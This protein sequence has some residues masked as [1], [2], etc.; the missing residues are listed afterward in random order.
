MA[1]RATKRRRL[2]PPDDAKP[3]NGM[4]R[5]GKKKTHAAA[6]ADKAL[7][8]GV[9][10]GTTGWD[11]EQEYESRPRKSK[12]EQSSKR[13]R[14]PIKTADGWVEQEPE[15]IPHEASEDEDEDEDSFLGSGEDEDEYEH[16]NGEPAVED[17]QP[18]IPMRQRILQAKEDLAK[19]AGQISEDPETNINAVR[20]L[21][22]FAD[23]PHVPVQKLALATQLAVYK[24][25]IPSYPIRPVKEDEVSSTKV[26]KEVR[27]LRSFEQTLLAGYHKYL[28]RLAGIAK[29]GARESADAAS[30]VTVAFSCA[31]N[32]LVS[33]TH[34]NFRDLLIGIVVRR[35]GRER[36]DGDFRKCVEC[37]ETLFKNDEDGYASLDAVKAL[38]TMIKARH[39]NIHE[40]VLN[41]FLSLRLLSELSVKGSHQRIDKTDE[42]AQTKSKFK[43]E[44]RTKRERKLARENKAIQKEFAEADAAVSHEDRDKNQSET[45]KIVFVV[46]FQILKKRSRKLMGAVLEG[47]AKY[48]H[49][50]NQD[51]F[52]DILEVLKELIS[53][54]S[55][56][57]DDN[58]DNT[59]DDNNNDEELASTS[60]R[61]AATRSSLLC[62]VTAFALLQG[63]DASY[64]T[65][66]LHLDLSFFVAHLYRT[67]LPVSLNPDIELNAKSLHLPDPHTTH[68]HA[69][70]PPPPDRK[71]NVQTTTVLLIRCLTSTLLPAH[72]ARSIPAQRIAAFTKHLLIAACQLPEKSALAMLG[73]LTL[74][75]KTHGKKVA[76]LWRTE[77][78]RGDGVFDPLC[79][80]P[81]ASNPFAS[82]AWEGEVLRVHF[83]PAVREA[84]REVE[85]GVREAVR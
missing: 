70:A 27:K 16:E 6:A 34:F 20:L 32:L 67:L 33:V 51:F 72:A 25:L 80:R 18:R 75:T 82:T 41:T 52:G 2:S 14:L 35:L 4:S 45:L 58:D 46:Y 26:S 21:E 8:H 42:S 1:V 23:A 44:F 69:P 17:E 40:N 30:L 11:D 28:Q 77:E 19:I 68:T 71:V 24:D 13:T 73:L 31:C 83:S 38:Q 29:A 22:E 47:L 54:A 85:R 79:E 55:L 49:L 62:C 9:F 64:A 50:I 60:V 66:T 37:L 53:N 43:K 10:A 7:E 3:P 5:A 61:Q 39:Y 76:A 12:T 63:Q 48:A 59:D 84:Y 56:Y 36:V 81:E 74:V 15:D 78:R 65:S 57:T